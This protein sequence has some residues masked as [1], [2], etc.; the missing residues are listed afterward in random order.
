MGTPR[1]IRTSAIL[2]LVQI[3]VDVAYGTCLFS[4]LNC[5]LWIV[6]SLVRSA[7]IRPGWRVAFA[8]AAIPCA[9]L[10]VTVANNSFQQR[11]ARHRAEAVT[12]AIHDFRNETGR[13][14]RTLHDLVPKHLT[15][16]PKTKYSLLFNDFHFYGGGEESGA[17]LWW[18][19]VPPYG[20]PYYNFDEARWS[21]VD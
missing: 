19:D 6:A 18:V 9:V 14:P 17:R 16:I 5:P 1:A 21:Y 3:G 8:R 2:G 4:V 11:I 20:R 7:W 12:Q 15:S 10:A 13:Y